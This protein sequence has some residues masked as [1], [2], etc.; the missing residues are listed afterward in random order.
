MHHARGCRASVL[1]WDFLQRHLLTV[2][3]AAADPGDVHR[4]FA[5][6]A[7]QIVAWILVV[8]VGS[9]GAA[10]GMGGGCPAP[11]ACGRLLAVRVRVARSRVRLTL[12]ACRRRRPVL[13]PSVFRAAQLWRQGV[14]GALFRRGHRCA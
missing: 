6:G 3:G 8:V 4:P 9:L 1:T 13:R 10:A 2:T 11:A 12:T 5:F 14:G 7:T